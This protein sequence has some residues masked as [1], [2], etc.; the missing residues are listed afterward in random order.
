MSDTRHSPLTIA[1]TVIAGTVLIGIDMT[2]VNIALPRLSADTGAA[3]PVIQWVATGYTLALAAVMPLTAW[4]IARLGARKVF[5]GSLALFVVGSALVAASWN[6][7][8]MIGFRILQGFA[9]GFVTPAA[10]TL[11]LTSAPPAERGRVMAILGLPILVGPVLGPVAGGWLLDNFSWRWMFLINVPLGVLS[12]ALGL[13]NLPRAPIGPTPR[14]DVRGLVLLPPGVALLVLAT[15]FSQGSVLA[16]GVLVPLALGVVLVAAFVRHALRTD[17]PL[18]NLRLLGRPLTGAGAIVLFLFS[19][20]YAGSMILIPL[21]WQVV[22][23]ESA[24]VTGLFTAPAALAAGLAIQISGRLVDRVRPLLVIGPGIAVALG[25]IITLVVQLGSNAPNWQLVTLWVLVGVGAGFTIMPMNTVSTRS[26]EN[27]A[28]PSAAT[29]IGVIAQVAGALCIAA[30]SVVLATQLSARLPGLAEGG[31]GDLYALP[32][33]RLAEL[34]PLIA[35]SVQ[36]ALWLPVGLMVAAGVVTVVVLRDV[37]SARQLPA[38]TA[39]A[40]ADRS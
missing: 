18:L 23:G 20:G 39:L 4:A 8:S 30:V 24:T 19:S 26:L 7:E 16:P 29:I 11:V 40:S 38:T 31:L 13:R 6:V 9:G 10:M 36:A 34:A 14:L 5:L 28:I 33:D 35:G 27:T 15:S 2:I 22:R 12:I 32:P 37:P 21:Y 17:A 25:A 3:L 1:L